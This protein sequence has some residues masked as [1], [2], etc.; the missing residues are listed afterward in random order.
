MLGVMGNKTPWAAVVDRYEDKAKPEV[1]ELKKKISTA[2]LASAKAQVESMIPKMKNKYPKLFVDD[3]A[4]MADE[5]EE[6]EEEEEEG[7]ENDEEEEVWED[8]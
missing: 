4:D 3:E 2:D 6:V 1:D 7:E 8:D 5:T